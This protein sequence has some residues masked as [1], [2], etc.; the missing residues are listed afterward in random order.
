M[1]ALVTRPRVLWLIKGLGLG[2]AERLLTTMASKVDRERF[3]IEVAYLLPRSDSFEA[4]LEA[5]GMETI[6]LNARWTAEPG[7]PTRLRRLLHERNYELI[8]THSPA[9]AIVARVLAGSGSRFVH[10]EHNLWNSYHRLTY[11]GNAATYSRNRHVFA[12]S[13]AVRASIDR[14]RWLGRRT[15]PAVETLHHGVDASQF[16]CGPAARDHAR[17]VLGLDTAT[18][19]IGSVAS[20]TPQKDHA[21]LLSA[22]ERVCE[23]IPEVQ[24]LLVGTGPQERE[25]RGLVE[26]RG[27]QEHVQFCGARTDLPELL[28][29]FDVFVLASRFEGLPISLLEAMASG[30][31]SVATRVGGVPEVLRADVEGRMVAPGDPGS[32][33]DAVVELLL[34]PSMRA[35]V[36]LGGYERVRSEF[37]IDRAVR[38]TEEVYAHVLGGFD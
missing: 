35:T 14:P 19:V 17:R 3:D 15:F 27:L 21:G 9:P 20:F 22:F 6:C 36:G 26:Q 23:Q 29:G 1:G 13:E 5:A 24:L 10:T 38:R 25:V 30:V 28:P 32:L 8:H 16:R 33:A 18:P 7:W 4:D 37:S 2:G 12:V 11:I 31:A 34:D